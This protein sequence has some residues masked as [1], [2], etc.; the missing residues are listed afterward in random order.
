MINYEAHAL[1]LKAPENSTPESMGRLMA[2][3]MLLNEV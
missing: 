3:A 2:A 1:Q